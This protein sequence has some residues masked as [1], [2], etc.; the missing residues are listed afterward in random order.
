ML[1][2]T[3]QHFAWRNNV[4]THDCASG[5]S[6]PVLV[7]QSRRSPRA[8]RDSDQCGGTT[9]SCACSQPL[10]RR[11]PLVSGDG[12][13]ASSLIGRRDKVTVRRRGLRLAALLHLREILPRSFPQVPAASTGGSIG[14]ERQVASSPGLLRAVPHVTDPSLPHC[15]AW[16]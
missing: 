7:V 1:P 9:R 10:W 6:W 5:K 2:L 13:C 12:S 16:C 4:Q 15:A 8:Q 3:V 14:R 11:A